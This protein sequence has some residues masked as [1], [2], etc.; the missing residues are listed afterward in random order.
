VNT[1]S[2]PKRCLEFGSYQ[3]R[4]D[5]QA[6]CGDTLLSRKINDENR[7]IAVLSD[8]LGSGTKAS[9]LSTLTATMALNYVAGF[10]DVKK[11]AE[12]IMR[13]LPVCKERGISY[14]T[15]IVLDIDA[16]GVARVI[17]YDSPVVIVVRDDTFYT[18]ETSIITGSVPGNRP[19]TL[20]Y[21]QF[22]LQ[23]GDRI[24]LYS[25]GVSQAG[26]GS[27]RYPLGWGD[28]VR[29]Y[30]AGYL[31]TDRSCSARDL[32]RVLVQQA[33]QLSD[34]LAR[35]DT[36]CA[37][38][39]YRQ[40]RQLL[41]ATGPPVIP[42]EDRNLAM[43]INSFVGTKIICGGT[44]AKIVARELDRAIR[45]SLDISHSDIPP[46]SEMQGIDLVT[47]G[48]ITLH[49]VEKLLGEG[50]DPDE[51]AASPAKRVYEKMLA[52]DSVHFVMGS[53]INEAY[54]DPLLPADIGLRRT[55]VRQIIAHLENKFHKET[56]L[57]IL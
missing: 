39:Y 35:D 36:S 42:G 50:K 29:S 43:T 24:V 23:A 34:G 12:T 51:V 31:S 54:Q 22:P 52:S 38:I 18:P 1:P 3:K 14:A 16:N 49:A 53:R 40:P 8:G 37:V 20:T 19:Y 9:V 17:N 56:H 30:I 57:Q 6:V 11:T 28:D 5:R 10:R 15:F 27:K 7:F 2:S 21:S 32:A 33:I 44:T 41:I 26:T 25:D 55:I 46:Q 4:K 13:T 47:E 48:I 45:S